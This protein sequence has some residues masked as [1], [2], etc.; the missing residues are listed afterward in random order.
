[1]S[2]S[3]SLLLSG[4]PGSGPLKDQHISSSLESFTESFFLSLP[5]LPTPTS[6]P[7]LL[8]FL[9]FLLLLTHI[10]LC[11][12]ACSLSATPWTAVHQSPP[13]KEFSRQEHWNG[14]LFPLSGDLPYPG[15]QSASPSS[16]ALV[17]EVFI[18]EPPGN[19]IHTQLQTA[20]KAEAQFSIKQ[21]FLNINI[22]VSHLGMLTQFRF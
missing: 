15:I 10:H 20:T 12:R 21:F 17:D 1:M 2:A 18:T 13:S 9:S 6:G 7:D 4:P 22:H 11:M 19:P 5:L 16:L 14:L 8:P 3:F